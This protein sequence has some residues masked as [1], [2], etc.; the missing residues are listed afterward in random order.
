MRDNVN[1]FGDRYGRYYTDEGLALLKSYG[2]PSIKEHTSV[3]K[4]KK[5]FEL[6]DLTPCRDVSCMV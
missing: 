2:K 6:K 4:L 1:K 3:Q 5:K